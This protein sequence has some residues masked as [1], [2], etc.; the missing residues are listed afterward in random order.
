L[1][2]ESIKEL[3]KIIYSSKSGSKEKT[4]LIS[5]ILNIVKETYLILEKEIHILRVKKTSSGLFGNG[6]F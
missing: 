4:R 1:L 5:L 6:L 2:D 3:W